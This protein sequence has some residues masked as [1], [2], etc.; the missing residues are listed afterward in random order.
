MYPLRKLEPELVPHTA[1]G[2]NLRSELSGDDWSKLK[3]F[4]G[5]RASYK[6][7]IGTIG[8]KWPVELH[9]HWHYDDKTCV[10]S[11]IGFSM[12]APDIHL[13]MHPGFAETIGKLDQVLKTMV[14]WN[15]KIIAGYNVFSAQE[16][17][18]KAF[19]LWRKRSQKQWDLD[20][21]YLDKI[22]VDLDFK[23]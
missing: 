7:E 8:P 21:S 20:L 19:A 9:E 15:S 6:C 4:F 23:G 22:G 16:D 1:W 2:K 5:K 13:C 18:R 14:F 10:Q 12:L 11:L 17:I 3:R